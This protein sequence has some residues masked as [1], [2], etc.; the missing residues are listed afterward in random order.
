MIA[1]GKLNIHDLL[2]KSAVEH[3]EQLV[4]SASVQPG[5]THAMHSY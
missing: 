4:Y 5:Q 2:N 1:N 3:R